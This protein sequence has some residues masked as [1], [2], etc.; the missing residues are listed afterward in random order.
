MAQN[1]FVS[2][3][4]KY[5]NR[6]DPHDSVS[7]Y[8]TLKISN[9]RNIKSDNNQTQNSN[10]TLKNDRFVKIYNCQKHDLPDRA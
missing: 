10:K 4:R 8:P 1:I 6:Y 9:I 3:Q 7:K 5:F 2:D